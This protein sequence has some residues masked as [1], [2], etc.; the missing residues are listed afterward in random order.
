MDKMYWKRTLRLRE[1]ARSL[2]RKTRRLSSPSIFGV[3]MGDLGG[4]Q[5][6][7]QSFGF[8]RGTPVD[9]YYI[10]QFLAACADDIHGQVLEVGDAIYSSRYGSDIERQDVLQVR[11]HADATIVADLNRPRSLPEAAFDCVIL[12]QTLQFIYQTEIAVRQLYDSLRAGGVLLATMPGVSSVDRGEWGGSWYWSF[13]RN[14]A[15]C[16][17]SETFGRTNVDVAAHGNVYAATAF[18]HGLA[19]EEID[20]NNLSIVDDAYPVIVTVRAV[21]ES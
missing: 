21:R 13:T 5:P 16:L 10:E 4:I 7:S 14:S 19:I 15:L 2:H 17:F 11:P 18:L 1:V 6:I 20:Q 8:D 9:R 12:T 3:E